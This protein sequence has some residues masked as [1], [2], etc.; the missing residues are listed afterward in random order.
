MK[1]FIAIILITQ[2][3]FYNAFCYNAL[4][5]EVKVESPSLDDILSSIE[6][7][8]QKKIAEKQKTTHKMANNREIICTKSFRSNFRKGPGTTFPIAY[9]ILV[10]GYPLQ[11]IK[12]V[13]T[14]YATEDFEGTI[15]WISEINIKKNCGVIVKTHGL[16]PVYIKPSLKTKVILSLE[17][18][19]IIDAIECLTKQ[20]CEVEVNNTKGWIQKEHIW[21]ELE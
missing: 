9:E 1:Y 4:A 18:G 5:G 16:T 15:A 10:R 2:A 3:L 8:S 17:R 19:F 13:D 12:Y 21:G 7:Q 20:W 14:W 11:V 6:E